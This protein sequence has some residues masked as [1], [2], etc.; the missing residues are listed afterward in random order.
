MAAETPIK[1]VDLPA[2]YADIEKGHRR[3]LAD[4]IH[5]GRVRGR[6][7]AVGLR[8]RLAKYCGVKFAV[9]CSDGTMALVLSLRAAGLRQ[10]TAWSCPPHVHRLRQRGGSRGRQAL[11]VDCDPHTYLLDLPQ[12]EAALKEG[13]ARFLLPVHLYGNRARCRK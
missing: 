3:R 2:Q 5:Q 12:T 13:R 8:G 1:F 4:L 6:G 9:G 10:A 7:G 11:P